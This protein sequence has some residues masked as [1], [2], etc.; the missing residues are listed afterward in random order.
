[1]FVLRR[2]T[3]EPC[4][5]QHHLGHALPL[6]DQNLGERGTTSFPKCRRHHASD[7]VSIRFGNGTRQTGRNGF[8][9][10]VEVRPC[11]LRERDDLFEKHPARI[12]GAGNNPHGSRSLIVDCQK[13]LVCRHD[14]PQV[15]NEVAQ[16]GVYLQTATDRFRNEAKA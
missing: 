13:Q 4:R 14:G 6:D 10:L 15:E 12:R 5:Q 11:F 3:V 16:G 1:L 8:E 2:I 7:R 9:L